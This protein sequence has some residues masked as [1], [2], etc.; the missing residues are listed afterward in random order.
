MGIYSGEFNNTIKEEL[1]MDI[2][3]FGEIILEI[4][5]NGRLTNAG[6]SIR[7]KPRESLL[8][9]ICNDNEVGSSSSLQEE[10]KLVLDVALLCIR[11]T[12]SDLPSMNDTLKFLS[13]LSPLS[14]TA[15]L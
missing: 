5:T 4:L 10:I 6:T 2:Y 13:R 3:G 1:Y 8:R 14:K 9:E 11:T 15:E 7:N 12:P